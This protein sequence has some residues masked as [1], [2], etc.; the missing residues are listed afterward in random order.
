MEEFLRNLE[1]P[2]KGRE[3]LFLVRDLAKKRGFFL[4]LAGGPV[5]D[6]LLKRTTKDIDL[7]L[8][9]DWEELLPI[10]LKET[11]GNL[12]F[13]SQFLTYKVQLKEGLTLDLVTARRETYLEP[14]SLPYVERAT[15]KE[16]ILRRDFTINALIYGL[17]PPFQ[18]KIVDLVSGLKDL[19]EGFINPLHEDSFVEDPTRALR[20][21]RYKV[22]FD[23]KYSL[24]FLQA[25][26]RAKKVYSFHKLSS[27]R[28][29]KELKLFFTKESREKIFDLILDLKKLSLFEAFSLKD[30]E[31]S[32]EDFS[33][34]EKAKRELSPKDLEKFYLLALVEIEEK[35]INRLG[36][37][38]EEREKILKYYNYLVEEEFG[39]KKELIEQI[40]FLERIPN[41]L[42]FRFG[43]EKRFRKL[44][45]FWENYR[46]IK[47]SLTGN[48]LKAMGI[49]EGEEIGKV[50]R[51]LRKRKL[52]GE[53]R[54]VE[55]EKN[56]VKT[57]YT[58]K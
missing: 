17:V 56:W 23:F 48:D 36:F 42:L 1:L 2:Q 26:E 45:K 58:K 28:L 47:P 3:F 50:L 37:L 41:Y 9:G 38:D 20:G 10:L 16:D 24:K 6:V 31:F 53:L 35:T 57:Y 21:V 32:R 40:E 34:I 54:T 5:R 43:L 55:E 52:L 27:A 12:L 44:F 7:V 25:L 4:Y 14:A 18:E 46:D 11:Q 33:I 30:R 19:R 15:F 22:R 49:K 29:A 8:E 39:K 51:E 13:K